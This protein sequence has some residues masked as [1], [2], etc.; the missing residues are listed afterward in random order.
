MTFVFVFFTSASFARGSR[1]GHSYSG[2]YHSR[3]Y[4]SPSSGIT[5]VKSYY[6]KNGTFVQSHRRTKAND[7]KYDNWSTKGNI[8]PDTGKEGYIDP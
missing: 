8:N 4:S 1:G 5:R 2:S 6:R 3:S 7:T